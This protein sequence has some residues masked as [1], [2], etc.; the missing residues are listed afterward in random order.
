MAHGRHSQDMQLVRLGPEMKSSRFTSREQSRPLF[1]TSNIS[2]CLGEAS[3]RLL[4]YCQRCRRV[5]THATVMLNQPIV[6]S[7]RKAL[8]TAHAPTQVVRRLYIHSHGTIA[9]LQ[10]TPNHHQRFQNDTSGMAQ[11][12]HRPD[13]NPASC[14][15][16]VHSIPTAANATTQQRNGIA[17]PTARIRPTHL[18]G[19]ELLSGTEIWKRA[20]MQVSILTGWPKDR[21]SRRRLHLQLC[22][23][24]PP[25]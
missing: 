24:W 5:R 6:L 19:F 11:R 12:F 18:A 25:P 1:G 3:P 14:R 23:C 7:C 2:G 17:P 15:W 16:N 13:A 21:S 10:A 9:N 20:S 4:P 8:P 22:G